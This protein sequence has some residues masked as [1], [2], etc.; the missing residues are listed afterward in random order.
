M[1]DFNEI[2]G[3]NTREHNP[4]CPQI[5]DHIYRILIVENSE[6]GKVNVPLNLINHQV[7]IDKIFCMPSFHTNKN[8]NISKKGPKFF[9]G[10]IKFQERKVLIV[11]DNMIVDVISD[12]KLHVIDCELYIMGRKLNILL[13]FIKRLYSWAPK[14]VGLS[15]TRIHISSL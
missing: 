3:E 12:K 13:V 5:P 2:I 4:S 14:D 11:F 9:H 7:D 6:S 15:N 10:I 1:I 8:I